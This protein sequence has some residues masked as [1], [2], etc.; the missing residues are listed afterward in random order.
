MGDNKKKKVTPL[1]KV[2]SFYNKTSKRA[3]AYA[4]WM[5]KKKNK[6]AKVHPE[7]QKRGKESMSEYESR[8]DKESVHDP[9]GKKGWRT[10]MDKA[11]KAIQ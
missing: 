4:T 7:P 1:K 8:K 9:K 10:A 5:K 2:T 11:M 3:N 6:S